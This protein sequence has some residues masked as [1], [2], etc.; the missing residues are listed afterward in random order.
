MRTQRLRK[1]LILANMRTLNNSLA[2]RRLAE[3][4]VAHDI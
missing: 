3:S 2:S 1:P 4:D